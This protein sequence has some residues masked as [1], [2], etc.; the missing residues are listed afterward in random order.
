[1][2]ILIPRESNQPVTDI[3]R[4]DYVREL[5]ASGCRMLFHESKMVHAKAGLIDDYGYIGS[6]NLDVRTCRLILKPLFLSTILKTSG[7]FPIGSYHSQKPVVKR[8]R[9]RASFV[10]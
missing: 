8:L 4:G 3:A 1:M 2:R 5:H 7:V 9:R 10:E 6:T